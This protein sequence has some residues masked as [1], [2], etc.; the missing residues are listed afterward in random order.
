MSQPTQSL[1]GLLASAPTPVQ[2]LR[3]VHYPPLYSL[4][5]LTQEFTN[6]RDEQNSWHT[7]AALLNQ[8]YHMVNLYVQG[9]DALRLFSDLGANSFKNFAVGVAKQFIALNEEGYLLGDAILAYLDT[10]S[11]DLMGE[12]G[13]ISWVQ[14]HIETGDY[15]VSYERED[16]SI[17]RPGDAKEYRYEIQGPAA[18]D[19]IEAA[20]GKPVPATKF[21]HIEEFTI[22]GHRV[23]GIRHGMAGQAGYE[24]FGP[25]AEREAVHD[26]LL[27]AGEKFGMKQAGSISYFTSHLE[28]GWFGR[29]VPAWFSGESTRAFREW[30]PARVAKSLGG[31]FDSDVIEDYYLTPFDLDYGRFTT[32]DHD[33]VGR[34]AALA[35][36]DKPAK[37]KVALIW[38][39]VDFADVFGGLVRPEQGAPPQFLDIGVSGRYS[40]YQYDAVRAGGKTIGFTGHNAYVSPER[41]FVALA[42]IDAEFAEPGTEVEQVWGDS[43]KLPRAQVENHRQVPVR[44]VVA[45]TPFGAFA[46]EKYRK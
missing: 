22:A 19:I 25:W 34:D 36:R 20:T 2:A 29:P 26:A 33:Y 35:L 7:T 31:S 18:L 45:P 46:R 40:F 16:N 15:N 13:I 3:A 1:A 6:W 21:F 39:D 9:P 11:F 27:A 42:T 41:R 14:F 17:V 4:P 37:K 32:D 44:A 30:A 28:G 38:D 12:P 43:L 10:D 23:R 24:L 5:G 8:S